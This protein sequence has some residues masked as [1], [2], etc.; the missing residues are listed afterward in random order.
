MFLIYVHNFFRYKEIFIP[1]V[2]EQ[3]KKT[4][5]VGKII[6][7]LDNAASHPNLMELNSVH[8]NS[9]VEYLLP[10]V[11]DQGLISLMKKTIKNI[12]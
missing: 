10:N 9:E 7:I 11:I 8:E 4:G 1:Q 2:L 3:Q 12:F 5:E 6:L